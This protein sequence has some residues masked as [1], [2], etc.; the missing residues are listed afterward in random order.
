MKSTWQSKKTSQKTHSIFVSISSTVQTASLAAGKSAFPQ[1]KRS[2]ASHLS[3]YLRKLLSC[4]HTQGSSCNLTLLRPRTCCCH[5]NGRDA[6]RADCSTAG[7]RQGP[8]PASPRQCCWRTPLGQVT[9][10]KKTT[11]PATVKPSQTKEERVSQLLKPS[12]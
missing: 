7:H 10:K 11:Q 9:K 3:S 4:L 1:T 12:G 5:G 8:Q 6:T 2:S